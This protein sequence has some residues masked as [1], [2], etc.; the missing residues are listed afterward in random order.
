MTGRARPA[1]AFLAVGVGR[2]PSLEAAR[3]A[4]DGAHRR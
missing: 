4:L 3:R 2:F 1:F